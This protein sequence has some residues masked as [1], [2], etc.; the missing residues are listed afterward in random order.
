M[1]TIPLLA[2]PAQTF[3]IILGGQD[4]R[5]TLYQR[6]DRLYSDLEAGDVVI[7]RGVI[8]QNL[9][10]LKSYT[11]LAFSG[12]LFFMDMEGDEDPV[13]SGL[14]TRWPL[15]YAAPGETIPALQARRVV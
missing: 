15:F 14:G 4:C 13:P 12:S 1:I 3:Q 8:C 5:L 7:W 9:V 6:G 2:I 11:Y 10:D